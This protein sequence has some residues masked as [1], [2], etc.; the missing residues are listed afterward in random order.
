MEGTLSP[1][2]IGYGVLFDMESNFGRRWFWRK[3]WRIENSH[4]ALEDIHYR[5]F[6]NVQTGFKFGFE[7]GQFS[8]QFTS[9]GKHGAHF[10][11]SSHNKHA[12]INSTGTVED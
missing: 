11:E 8:G 4:D 6:M 12:H 10:E 1:C 9:V 3:R 2:A 7:R 5:R